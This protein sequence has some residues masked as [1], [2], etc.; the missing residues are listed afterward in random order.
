MKKCN[1]ACHDTEF[2]SSKLHAPVLHAFKCCENMNGILKK[3]HKN[4]IKKFG[5]WWER[6]CLK[7]GIRNFHEERDGLQ[8]GF[9]AGPNGENIHYI[10]G[11]T[12]ETDCRGLVRETWHTQDLEQVNEL[13]RSAYAI[14]LREGRTTNWDA[15]T[16]QLKKELDKP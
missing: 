9:G 13:L 4:E 8:A 1:C 15:F 5:G 6:E 16:K 12:K 3:T 11:A 2:N 10:I 14:T 7:C